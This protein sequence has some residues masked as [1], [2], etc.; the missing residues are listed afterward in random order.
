MNIRILNKL[1]C[2]LCLGD[3]TL[4]SFVEESIKYLQKLPTIL[5]GEEAG[6]SEDNERIIK[7]GVL[8]C[9]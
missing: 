8:L 3:L 4:H 9:Q 1:C 7:D 2:P 6:S 5:E